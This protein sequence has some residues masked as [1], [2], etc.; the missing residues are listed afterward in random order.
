MANKEQLEILRKGVDVWNK[1][2]KNNPEIKPDL[3]EAKLR[4][5]LLVGANLRGANLVGAY[6][7]GAYLSRS[8]L[9]GATLGRSDLRGAVLTVANLSSAYLSEAN[10]NE[11]NLNEADITGAKLYGTA[12]D[13]WKIDG[14][15]CDYVYFDFDGKERTPKDRNFRPGEFEELYKQLPTI[16]YYFEN[17][18]TPIDAIVIDKVVQAINEKHPEFELKLDSFHSRGQPHAVFTILHKDYADEAIKQIR[19]DYEMKIKK[20]EGKQESLMEVI[21]MYMNKP[22]IQLN[23]EKIVQAENIEDRSIHAGGDVIDSTLAA[24]DGNKL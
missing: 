3:N 8:D 11:A 12:R 23:I 15:K 5:A 4:G 9:R 1:W 19:D 21:S 16:E 18:F 17:G 24:G 7:A 13:N 6:L 22:Q 2:R 10:L 20:L 14:I